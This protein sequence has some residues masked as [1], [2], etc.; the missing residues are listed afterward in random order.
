MM[1]NLVRLSVKLCRTS[2]E[3]YFN[4]VAYSTKLIRYVLTRSFCNI[5]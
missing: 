2:S 1:A 5:F 4:H 3:C